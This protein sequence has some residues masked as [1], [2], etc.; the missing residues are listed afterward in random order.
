MITAQTSFLDNAFSKPNKS[1]NSK[2]STSC[3]AFMGA[4][5]LELSVTATAADVRP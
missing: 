5:I 1:P 2:I 4:I 3:C